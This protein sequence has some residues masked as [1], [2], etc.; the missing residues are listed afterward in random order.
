VK[1]LRKIQR[2]AHLIS[3]TAGDLDAAQRGPTVLAK[4]ILR[5]QLT[6]T[7]FRRL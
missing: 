1:L 3:R 4:R 6:R 2:D 5:R 7:L